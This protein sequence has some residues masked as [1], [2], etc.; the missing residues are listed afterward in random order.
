MGAFGSFDAENLRI[1]AL[2]SGIVTDFG[3]LTPPGARVAGYVRSTGIQDYDDEDV[4]RRLHLTLN[5]ALAQCRSGMGDVVFVLPGHVESI[6]SAD[7]A[8]SLKAGTKIIGLGDGNLRPVFNWTVAGSTFLFDV[9]NVALH[10]CILNLCPSTG[11]VTVAAPITVSAAGCSI[12]GCRIMFGVDATH[13]VTI[14]VT[15]TAGATDFT[16]NNEC[17]SATAAECTTF[18]QLVGAVRLRLGGKI[19]GATSSTGVGLVRFLTTASIDVVVDGLVV[20]NNKAASIV[21]ITG[22]AGVTGHMDNLLMITLANDNLTNCFGTSLGSLS[23][24]AN[25]KVSNNVTETAGQ[26][27]TVSA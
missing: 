18:L 5:G 17:F 25:C 27:G 13:L 26:F 21:A 12:T 9:A 3:V 4:K 6:S 8:S 2:S 1:M 7:Y 20:R 10:N 15:T 22:M 16:F 19:S 11:T 23:F 14:G 24:G